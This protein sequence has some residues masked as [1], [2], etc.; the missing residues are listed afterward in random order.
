MY[1]APP[2]GAPYY[3]AP[4]V[5]EA[6]YYAAPPV[7]EAPYYAAPPAAEAPPMYGAPPEGAPYYA[8]PP[9]A[10]TPYYAAP[11]VAETPYYAAP[12]VAETPYY[13]APPAAETPYYTAPPVA[14]APYNAAPP[15]AEAPPMYGALPAAEAP[16]YAAPPAAETPY[17][18]EPPADEAPAYDI[19]TA[20]EAIYTPAPPADEAPAYDMPPAAEAIYTPAPPADEAPA[21]ELPPTEED[22]YAPTPPAAEA[23]YYA[24]PPA[25]EAP[26][27]G[28]P[29]TEEIPYYAAPPAGD[30]PMYGAPP[31]E[32]VYT[33]P[34]YPPGGPEYAPPAQAQSF[35]PQPPPKSAGGKK[36]I[37][38]IVIPIAA[39]L[40]LLGA[41]ACLYFFTDILP[42]GLSYKQDPPI[43]DDIDPELTDTPTPT[44]SPISDPT[45]TPTPTPSPTPEDLSTRLPGGGGEVRV[46]KTTNYAFTP[47]KSGVW[48]F[49]TFSSVDCDP[50]LWIYDAYGDLLEED[51]D[52]NADESMNALIMIDLIAGSDYL[53]KAGFFEDE[54]EEDGSYTLAVTY[55]GERPVIETPYD[56]IPGEGAMIDVY[57]ETIYSFTPDTTGYWH[58]QTVASEE[59]DP[60]ITVFDSYGVI[61]DSDDDT[62]G[63]DNAM[64]IVRLEAGVTYSIKVS[65][66][67]DESGDC[68]LLVLHALDIANDG[69]VLF[70]PG[71]SAILF[72]PDKSGTWELRTS[73]SG[74]CDPI[75]AVMDVS[76]GEIIADSDDIVEGVDLNSFISVFLEEGETYIIFA[77]S[78]SEEVGYTLTVTRK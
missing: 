19:P 9:V 29:P 20:A 56:V 2:E 57:D 26:A 77:L 44:P 43:V 8:A 24:A 66:Y 40:V 15:A 55:I 23:P 54:N 4:P 25:E 73:D 76:D 32:P 21:Y 6:P 27:Y 64:L 50:K 48:E 39:V 47:D 16:Y 10:E 62:I 61:I 37:L 53:V 70:I 60:A 38:K 72:T 30:A 41:F 42:F 68:M 18:P 49:R 36:S 45:P 34:P 75:M 52:G 46:T 69:G 5:A 12:P 71:D 11:P 58:L 35:P 1:T 3:A 51:D 14:E 7:A 65:F 63:D 22:P 67:R 74:E 13:A 17:T 33:P 28:L 59:Y 78:T 31:M